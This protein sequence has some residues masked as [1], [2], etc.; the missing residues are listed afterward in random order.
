MKTL[1]RI[2]AALAAGA[3]LMYY[4]DPQSGRRRRALVRERGLAAG[5]DTGRM[6]A[7]KSRF[8][9]DRARGALARARSVL[10]E[11]VPPDDVLRDRV[12][13]R[14][15]H[16][17]DA[18]AQVDVDVQQG[19]VVLRGHASIEEIEDLTT[20]LSAMRGVV[21]VDNRIVPAAGLAR[22]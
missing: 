4:L 7:G 11:A 13:S 5:H 16:M 15:G 12:R 21:G 3:A 22:P 14:L 2:A 6:L 18:P 10:E 17:I 1:T 8:A 19:Y 20:R 9:S